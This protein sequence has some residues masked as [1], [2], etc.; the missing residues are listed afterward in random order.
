MGDPVPDPVRELLGPDASAP[1]EAITPE[2]VT[3]ADA[4]PQ[5]AAIT[6]E[7]MSARPGAVRY[8]AD[9]ARSN[10]SVRTAEAA[11][12]ELARHAKKAAAVLGK[13]LDDPNSWVR[14]TA[15]RAILDKTVPTFGSAADPR[16]LGPAIVLPPGTRIALVAE[17]PGK[18]D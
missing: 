9:Y 5:P 11:L 15:A 4:L 12:K 18:E 2:V 7:V 8:G 17:V 6:P 14:L 10:P 16:D 1:P 3:P 13:N